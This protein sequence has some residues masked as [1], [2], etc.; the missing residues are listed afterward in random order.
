MWETG[1]RAGRL[2]VAAD[3]VEEELWEV[4]APV[5]PEEAFLKQEED[6]DAAWEEVCAEEELL[7][8]D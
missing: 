7:E 6:D 5:T 4:P 1:T 3:E 8:E 2:G